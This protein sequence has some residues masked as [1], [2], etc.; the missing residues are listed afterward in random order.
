MVFF[1]YQLLNTYQTKAQTAS[2]SIDS[3][4]VEIGSQITLTLAVKTSEG[5][6]VTVPSFSKNTIIPDLEIVGYLPTDTLR[7]QSGKMA[8]MYRYRITSFEDSTFLIPQMPV[9]VGADTMYTNSVSVTYTKLQNL[10]STFMAGIDTTKTLKI[11]DVTAPKETPLTFSE[12]WARF[13]NLIMIILVVAIA[14]S[15]TTYVIVRKMRNKPILPIMKPKEPAENVAMRRLKQLRDKK[16]CQNEKTKEYYSELTEI[17][18]T[19]ISDRYGISVMESTSAETL[20]V[21][22]QMTGMK[23]DPYWQMDYIFGIA[24]FVKFA[25]MQPLPDEND[26][27]MNLAFQFVEITKPVVQAADTVE[28][29][30]Q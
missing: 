24:D 1:T 30:A 3:N 19:Y 26:K 18:K 2:L 13:G 10:D 8:L 4:Y 17:L 22:A 15:L 9:L 20:N 25:K 11:F 12:F 16:L 21:I 5:Q 7:D 6:Q 23:S 27:A 28:N 14:A 29:V